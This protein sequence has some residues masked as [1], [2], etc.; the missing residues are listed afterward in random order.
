MS[1]YTIISG[2][3]KFGS[4]LALDSDAWSD[5][6]DWASW[7]NWNGNPDNLVL[8]IDDEFDV[9]AVRAPILETAHK[10]TLTVSLKVSNT[11]AFAGEETTYS[12]TSTAVAIAAGKYYRWT[13]T[14]AP[15]TNVTPEI[16][17]AQARY[18]EVYDEQELSGVDTSTLS[19]T[20]T[21]RTITHNLGTLNTVV[22]TAKEATPWVDRAYA[23]PDTYVDPTNI[24]PIVGIISKDPLTIILRDDFGVPVNGI[25]DIRLTGA[26]KVYLSDSGVTI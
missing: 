2:E 1:T 18:T 15:T 14:V 26:P 13:L 6:T 16:V 8:Q 19:G 25:V 4:W 12:I 7:T 9:V 24:A 11:G 5:L 20:I 17:Y 21:G 3:E 22:I 23:L 10:G